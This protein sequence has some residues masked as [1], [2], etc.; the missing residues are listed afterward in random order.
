MIMQPD[1]DDCGLEQVASISAPKLEYNVPGML[2][3]AFQ[4]LAADDYPICKFEIFASLIGNTG[5][6]TLFGN[7]F[8]LSQTLIYIVATFTNTLKFV[9]KDC[10][11]TTGEPDEEGYEDEYQVEDIDVLTGDYIQPTYISNFADVWEQL[12]ETEALETFALEKDKAPSLKGKDTFHVGQTECLFM[13][14]VSHCLQFLFAAACTSIIDLLG[15]QALEDS[16]LPKSNTVHTLILSG[17]FIGGVKVLAR[18]RMTFSPATGVAFE[19][20]VRSED[21][22][23]SQIVLGAIA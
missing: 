10:D 17:M 18:S 15:M 14:Q 20:A 5:L 12:A 19:L 13:S 8:D 22:N 2:Y 1:V 16:A 3:L 11:P 9:V 7:T 4:K 23:V 6:I 21:E